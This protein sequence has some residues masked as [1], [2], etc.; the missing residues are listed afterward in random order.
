MKRGEVP[1]VSSKANCLYHDHTYPLFVVDPCFLEF[2]DDKNNIS[3]IF[4]SQCL[5]SGVRGETGCVRIR[6]SGSSRSRRRLPSP[7]G[8]CERLIIGNVL[9][10]MLM[11]T[12]M[13]MMV[14]MI[15]TIKLSPTQLACARDSS[16][17]I[18]WC[19]CCWWWWWCWCLPP[20][21]L[22]KRLLI[23]NMMMVILMMVM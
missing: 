10:K 6:S 7:S 12:M 21:G 5:C 23:G 14:M 9:M 11:M 19:W 16:S 17:V 1:L 20:S 3:N 15:L 4:V 22:R 18:W 13:V 8:L 2:A